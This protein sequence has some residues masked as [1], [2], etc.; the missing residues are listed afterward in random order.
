[1]VSIDDII[2]VSIELNNKGQDKMGGHFLT[3]I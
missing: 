2:S 1:M 3:E